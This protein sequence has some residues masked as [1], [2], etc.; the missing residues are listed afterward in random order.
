MCLCTVYLT[1]IRTHPATYLLQDSQP[2]LELCALDHSKPSWRF[3]G[4][5]SRA[6]EPHLFSGCQV[7]WTDD[8]SL[9]LKKRMIPKEAGCCRSRDQARESGRHGLVSW[10]LKC[11]HFLFWG[12]RRTT[13]SLQHFDDLQKHVRYELF[14]ITISSR[15]GSPD[16]TVAKMRY[17]LPLACAKDS[18]DG[19]PCSFL[20]FLLAAQTFGSPV[21]VLGTILLGSRVDEIK[22]KITT[23]VLSVRTEGF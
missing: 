14:R 12:L 13:L 17:S 3:S 1:S 11:L 21:R 2:C 9:F 7:A 8:L 20:L 23:H 18:M 22:K 16:L 10:P 4:V 19:L 15:E 5:P 6:G